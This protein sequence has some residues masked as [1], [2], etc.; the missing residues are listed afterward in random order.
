[1]LVR[2]KYCSSLFKA[3]GRCTDFKC[4]HGWVRSPEPKTNFKVN[5][6]KVTKLRFTWGFKLQLWLFNQINWCI[7]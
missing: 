5:F 6:K 3:F 2:L 4:F 7:F 1:L